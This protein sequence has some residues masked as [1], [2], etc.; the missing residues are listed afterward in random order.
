MDHSYRIAE[1][2]VLCYG[3]QRDGNYTLLVSFLLVLILNVIRRQ[4]K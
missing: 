3:W 4:L 1:L 2:T